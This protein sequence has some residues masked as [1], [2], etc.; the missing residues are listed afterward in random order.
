MIYPD[1]TVEDPESVMQVDLGGSSANFSSS[2]GFS[3]YFPAPLY[4]KPAVEKYFAAHKPSY[5]SYSQL[6]ANF[7]NVTGLYNRIGRGYPDV[8]A[9]GARMPA[10]TNGHLY[11]YYGASLSSPIFASVLTLVSSFYTIL[12]RSC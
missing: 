9:N 4:Q 5:A 6:N 12:V 11:H 2:G 1:Q 10:Y 8:A 7:A 3:N